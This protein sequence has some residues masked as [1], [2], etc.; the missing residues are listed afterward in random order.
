MFS[1]CIS[2]QTE[3]LIDLPPDRPGI[4]NYFDTFHL[5]FAG[6]S[7]HDRGGSLNCKLVR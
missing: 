5:K 3:G 2:Q 1:F 7:N 4:K 6:G